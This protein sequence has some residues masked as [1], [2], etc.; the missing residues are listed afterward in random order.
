V[1]LPQSAEKNGKNYETN[2]ILSMITGIFFDARSKT[3]E[4]DIRRD[5]A[6]NRLSTSVSIAANQDG[7]SLKLLH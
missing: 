6:P 1:V 2:P 7:D 3:A 4:P 5:P